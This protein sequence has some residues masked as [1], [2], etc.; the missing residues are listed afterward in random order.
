MSTSR[1]K[2]IRIERKFFADLKALLPISHPV[3]V[4]LTRNLEQYRHDKESDK[5]L[6]LD[7]GKLAIEIKGRALGFGTEKAWLHQ[8]FA[9]AVNHAAV[10]VLVV[11]Y[12]R[13]PYLVYLPVIALSPFFGPAYDEEMAKFVNFMV[14]NPQPANYHMACVSL[15]CLAALILKMSA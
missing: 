6:L 5:L 3:V 10:P 13:K 2:G 8:V 15:E 7:K 9:S 11:K 14:S 4:H 1:A 12:D